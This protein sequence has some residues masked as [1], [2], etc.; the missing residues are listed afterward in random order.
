MTDP[1]GS[2]TLDTGMLLPEYVPAIPIMLPGESTGGVVPISPDPGEEYVAS[3]G[4]TPPGEYRT[5]HDELSDISGV[6]SQ[7][8]YRAILRDPTAK[9]AFDTL[10][11]A[12]LSGGIV[13]TAAVKPGPDDTEPDPDAELAQ[14]IA[15]FCR[16]CADRLDEHPVLFMDE[17]L[18]SMVYRHKVAEL[19][20]ELA[21]DG[22][23][24]GRFVLSRLPRKPRWSYRFRVDSK[25]KVEYLRCLVDGEGEESGR[26]VW[27]D[28][29]A[30]KF[31]VASWAAEDG[32][33]RGNSILDAAVE[34]W[35]FKRNLLPNWWKGL[36]QFGS[37]S[38]FGTTHEGAEDIPQKDAQG[39]PLPP[40]NPQ[41][42]MKS[43]LEAFFRSGSVIVGPFGS[44]VK[45]VESGRDGTANE[46]A[47][48]RCDRDITRAILKQ[49]RATGEAR[50][51]SKA[52]SQTGQ[53]I[54]EV[55]VQFIRLWACCLLDAQVFYRLVEANWGQAVAERLSPN[56]SLGQVSL[57]DFAKAA[58]AVATLF[59][60][61]YFTEGQL[62][63]TDAILGLPV[64]QA[65]DSRV[66]PQQS[67][68]SADPQAQDAPPPEDG[69]AA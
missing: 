41:K 59:Q 53:D 17:M 25:N 44:N 61:S 62:S 16:R 64:R 29:P 46:K 28:I 69:A 56:V 30:W 19:V 5:L 22:P 3:N 10:K 68:A 63:E 48:E 66:G 45:V 13:L 51:G 49:T 2:L 35:K 54:M 23:D 4:G 39:N 31:V 1:F 52:D 65:G 24:A 27:R 47:L 55:Y 37:P 20:M 67:A 42:A 43:G 15:D 60:S 36:K 57:S 50:F 21:A 40:L 34:A 38:L 58:S 26:L 12:V 18:D 33:P 8:V 14:E 11:A 32:D 6:L 9:P 7:A